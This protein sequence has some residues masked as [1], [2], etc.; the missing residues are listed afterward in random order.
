MIA[1][2]STGPTIQEHATMA[3]LGI[4]CHGLT[5]IM[6]QKVALRSLLGNITPSSFLGMHPLIATTPSP[7]KLRY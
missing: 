4:M 6:K 3:I 7:F 2:L 5:L 1:L